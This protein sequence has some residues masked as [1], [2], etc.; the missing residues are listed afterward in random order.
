MKLNICTLYKSHVWSTKPF[1][2][3]AIY[4][5]LIGKDKITKAW[6]NSLRIFAR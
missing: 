2:K 6:L 3:C 4:Q 1:A 5:E